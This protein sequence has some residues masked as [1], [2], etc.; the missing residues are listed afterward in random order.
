MLAITDIFCL[1]KHKP[2]QVLKYRTFP[3]NSLEAKPIIIHNHECIMVFCPGGSVCPGLYYSF[4]TLTAALVRLTDTHNIT[5]GTLFGT[6]S[7]TLSLL[8]PEEANIYDHCQHFKYAR[9]NY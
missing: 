3:N 8:F 4:Y 9:L 1:T 7:N 5:G 2:K 6:L